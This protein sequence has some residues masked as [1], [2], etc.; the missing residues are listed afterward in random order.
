MSIASAC[1]EW[2]MW[3]WAAY[4]DFSVEYVVVEEFLEKFL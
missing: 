1:F 2:A 4:D 3:L